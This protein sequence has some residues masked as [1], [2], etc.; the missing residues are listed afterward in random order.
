M[1]K[2]VFIVGSLAI[3]MAFLGGSGQARNIGPCKFNSETL[4]FSGTVQETTSCL[5]KKV[6]PKGAGA[7]VQT[8]PPWLLNRV[9]QPFP[10]S[11][12]QVRAYLEANGVSSSTITDRLAA[13][14]A[15]SLRYFV[16]HDTSSPEFQAPISDF[17]A[18]I[19]DSSWPGN[20]L[21]G[22]V[23]IAERVNLLIS[24]DGNSRVL[25]PWG[26]SRSMP[27]TKLEQ[28]SNVPTARAVFAH[29]ENIQ[30]RIKPAGSWGWR[31]PEP[32][33]SQLQERRLAEAYIVASLH[34][35]R[36]LIPAYHFNIDQGMINAHDDPQNMNL[37]SWVNQIEKIEA[38]IAGS[39]SQ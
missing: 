32:G 37:V 21:A 38:A 12:L 10:H 33:L 23:G 13:N 25:R 17:P 14:D 29:V 30:P 9:A 22:W 7:D 19:N 5:L 24:R 31:A 28:G 34:A 8:I 20:R 3:S 36:W 11:A 18:N 1:V 39:I 16:I 4:R 26:A 15:P 6:R 2:K 27:A 35:G